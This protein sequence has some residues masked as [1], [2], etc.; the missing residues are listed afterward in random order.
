MP[1]SNAD[2]ALGP[3]RAWSVEGSLGTMYTVIEWKATRFVSC[4]CPDWPRRKNMIAGDHTFNAPSDHHCKHILWVRDTPGVM[5]AWSK[6]Q[7]VAK[8]TAVRPLMGSG[9][10][11]FTSTTRPTT[12]RAI[13]FDEEV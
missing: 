13:S 11:Q 12:D 7:I 2:K 10:V 1:L 9:R 3:G 8:P 5:A 4:N 6:P